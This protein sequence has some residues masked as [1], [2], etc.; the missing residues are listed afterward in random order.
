MSQLSQRLDSIINL[1]ALK[2]D[3]D[4][5]EV[6]GVS[7]S[8]RVVVARVIFTYVVK[9]RGYTNKD[10]SKLLN[11]DVSTIKYYDGR[12]RLMLT[13]PSESILIESFVKV[14]APYFV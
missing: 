10:I 14:L 3:V 13:K 7:S 9:Q 1:I 4:P 2:L 12:A 11:K 5:L 8:R 6:L